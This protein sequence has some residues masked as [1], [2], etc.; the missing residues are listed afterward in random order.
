MHDKLILALVP[1]LRHVVSNDDCVIRQ[2]LYEAFLVI[3]LDV[4]V[5]LHRVER[6]REVSGRERRR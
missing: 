3:W 2:L 5:E 4:E 1:F 6:R